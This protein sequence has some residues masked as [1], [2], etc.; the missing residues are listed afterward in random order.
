LIYVDQFYSLNK[1]WFFKEA[2]IE[3]QDP[4]MIYNLVKLS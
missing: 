2:R 1:I 4:M 3:N